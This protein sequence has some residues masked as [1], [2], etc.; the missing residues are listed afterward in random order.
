M[1]LFHIT[2]RNYQIG[3]TISINDYEGVMSVNC[4]TLSGLGGS[5]L[6]RSRY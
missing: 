2:E 3:E 1:R 5:C 6:A 4:F